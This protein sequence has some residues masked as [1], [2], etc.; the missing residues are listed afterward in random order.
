[1]P[2]GP[3]LLFLFMGKDFVVS[4][5]GVADG[6]GERR[7]ISHLSL[8]HRELARLKGEIAHTHSAQTSKM[9]PT[10]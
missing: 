8:P 6:V 7:G 9:L 4:A 3:D 1:M 5:F 2:E 10:E